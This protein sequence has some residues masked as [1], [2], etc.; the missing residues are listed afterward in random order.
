MCGLK[1]FHDF[2]CDESEAVPNCNNFWIDLE[3]TVKMLRKPDIELMSEK[4]TVIG[5]LRF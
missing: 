2:I 5:I 1:T 3:E 4:G